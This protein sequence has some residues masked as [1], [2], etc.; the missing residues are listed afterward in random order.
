M[1]KNWSKKDEKALWVTLG[2]L[3]AGAAAAFIVWKKTK[4]AQHH[5]KPPR[6]A[7]QLKLENPG[8]QDDFPKP[9]MESEIG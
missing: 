4:G 3:L 8:S 7:P 6:R 5:E 2:G 9:P 1:K